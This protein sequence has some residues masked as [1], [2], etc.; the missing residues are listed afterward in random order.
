MSDQCTAENES[1]HANKLLIV[2]QSQSGRNRQL[3]ESAYSGA[4][5][6]DVEIRLLRA[7][8]AGSADLLWA[9]GLIIVGPENFGYLSGGIKDFFDRSFYRVEEKQLNLPYALIVS[10]GN[11]GSNAVSQAERIAKGYP[12]KPIAEPLII[13]GSLADADEQAAKDAGQALAAGL[14]MGIF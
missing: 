12:F 4:E 1:V 9:S 3:A 8:E 5:L 2:Y 14:S 10:C 13:K 7:Q 6:E 11:D